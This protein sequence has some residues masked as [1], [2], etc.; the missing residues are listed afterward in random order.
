MMKKSIEILKQIRQLVFKSLNS[1]TEEQL[2]NIPEG[3]NNNILWNVGHV[4][5][6]QQA[7]QYKLSGLEMYITEDFYIDF[8]KGSSPDDWEGTPDITEIKS[9]LLELPEKL[10]QDYHAK[11]FQDF[12]EYTTSAGIV[13]SDIEDAILFNNFHEGMHLGIIMSIR[14]YV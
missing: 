11:K 9:L 2:L 1:F 7:L 6:V 4:I 8:Q 13:L 14:K 3:R 5:A 10:D 12:N